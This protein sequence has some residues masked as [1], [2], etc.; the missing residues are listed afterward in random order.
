[1]SLPQGVQRV[2]NGMGQLR[3]GGPLCPSLCPYSPPCSYPASPTVARTTHVSASH[4]WSLVP[5]CAL[6][7]NNSL[8]P[9]AVSSFSYAASPKTLSVSALFSQLHRLSIVPSTSS[10]PLCPSCW[11]PAP[12][13]HVRHCI[14]ASFS[15]P[16][17][18]TGSVM[19]HAES[20]TGPPTHC[21][22]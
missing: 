5:L 19:L 7:R 22:G 15:L 9:V 4:L 16:P 2:R 3:I 10:F 12:K 20:P 6:P 17:V 21:L 13:V 1:M 11:T 8:Q 14:V 18:P